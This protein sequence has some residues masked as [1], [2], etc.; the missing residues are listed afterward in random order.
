MTKAPVAAK[1]S[2]GALRLNLGGMGEGFRESQIPGFKTVDLRDGADFVADVKDLGFIPNGAVEEI[3]A[4]N[5]LEHFPHKETVTVLKEWKRVL[6]PGGLLWISVPDFDASVRLYQQH[7][8]VNWVKFLIW[9][10]QEHQL[11]YHYINFTWATLAKALYDAGFSECVKVEHLPYGVRDAS[12]I[13][14]SYFKKPISLN[15]KAIA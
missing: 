3:Y 15:V 2:A 11:N 10:D 14:D 9:G 7:G 4:S 6:A 5:V 13:V 12:E 1:A 8:M